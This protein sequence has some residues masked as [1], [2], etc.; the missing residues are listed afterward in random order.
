M[1]GAVLLGAPEGFVPGVEV[2]RGVAH[3]DV[4]ALLVVLSSTENPSSASS[5]PEGSIVY[6]SRWV[7][8]AR[9][10]SCRRL[11]DHHRGFWVAEGRK[12]GYS[13]V[14]KRDS[15]TRSNWSPMVLG[16]GW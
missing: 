1:G 11:E 8:L 3:V 13:G 14:G 9:T 6:T 15:T 2:L 12:R 4:Q 7:R 16:F 10:T 5:L